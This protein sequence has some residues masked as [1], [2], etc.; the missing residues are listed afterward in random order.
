MKKSLKQISDSIQRTMKNQ[1]CKDDWDIELPIIKNS[2][3][4]SNV[5][6]G[7][8]L[9]RMEKRGVSILNLATA[10]MNSSIVE[11]YDIG[12]YPDYKNQSPIRNLLGEDD[13]GRP[14]W[15]GVAIDYDKSKNAIYV[16]ALTTVFEAKTERQQKFVG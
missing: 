2:I 15:I 5:L 9:K 6:S 3:L 7:H 8:I 1:H 12:K 14:L 13:L 10:L 11:G 4:K 16:A